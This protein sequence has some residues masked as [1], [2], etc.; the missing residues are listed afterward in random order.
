MAKKEEKM[1]KGKI[2]DLYTILGRIQN[3]SVSR[4]FAYAAS[5]NMDNIEKIKNAI[6]KEEKKIEG[7]EELKKKRE[8]LV[9]EHAEKDEKGNAKKEP[10]EGGFQYV[11]EDREAFNDATEALNEEYKATLD[12]QEKMLGEEE[13]VQLHKVEMKHVPELVSIGVMRLIKYF[14]IEDI[15][16][17]THKCSKCGHEEVVK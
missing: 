4:K 5:I 12:E 10:I 17:K 9:E 13:A 7:W 8:E 16:K 2:R 11:I 14:I 15:K 1:Q 3:Q 6:D